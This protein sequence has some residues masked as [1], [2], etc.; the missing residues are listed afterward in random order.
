MALSYMVADKI[1]SGTLVPVLEEY[2]PHAVP[3]HLVYAQ[4]KL[5]APKVRAFLD[6]SADRLR[7]KIEGT[8]ME[9]L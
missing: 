3:I 9:S 8:D 5:V 1:R 2:T 4:S 7:T 6:F